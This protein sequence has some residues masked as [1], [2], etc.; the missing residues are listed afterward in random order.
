VSSKGRPTTRPGIPCLIPV[1]LDSGEETVDGVI[2][3]ISEMAASI[4][5]ERPF[6]TV[7][8]VLARFRR[9]GDREEVEIAGSI[10]GFSRAGGIW[11]GRPSVAL[12]FDTDLRHATPLDDEPEPIAPPPRAEPA[13]PVPPS[14][15]T[16]EAPVPELAAEP[17]PEPTS[18]PAPES[19]PQPADLWEPDLPSTP[20]G[21]ES[22]PITWPPTDASE[23]AA[24]ETT[25]GTDRAEE[26]ETPVETGEPLVAATELPEPVGF[27]FFEGAYGEASF[28]GDDDDLDESTIDRLQHQMQRVERRILT[29]LPVTF[30]VAG[31]EH[32]G[33]ACNFS[34]GG[35]YMAAETFPKV[36]TVVH[37]V[38]P[39]KTPDGNDQEVEFN[40][41]VRWYRKDRPDLN[42]PD[43]YGLQIVS[44]EDPE[45]RLL[46]IA[47]AESI[48]EAAKR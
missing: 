4:S 24:S 10:I 34:P 46:Y 39:L 47:F 9:P 1:H 27:D 42:L 7:S 15:A 30:L 26:P 35:L 31:E 16:P 25:D 3:R 17:A 41:V 45:D 20:P 22:L 5:L 2:T 28:S 29:S 21:S 36:G 40:G 32:H 33:L 43:G 19:A 18:E 38:F 11:R 8:R 44:F 6:D 48:M 37:V 14:P 13:K 23:L 12:R